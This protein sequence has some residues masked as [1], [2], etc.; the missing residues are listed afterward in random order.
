MDLLP[1]LGLACLCFPGLEDLVGVLLS[2]IA[3]AKHRLKN[4]ILDIGDTFGYW[5]C[6]VIKDEETRRVRNKKRIR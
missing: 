5:N 4:S 3:M 2:C 6:N 1:T